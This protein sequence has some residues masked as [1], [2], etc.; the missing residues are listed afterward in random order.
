MVFREGGG[1]IRKAVFRVVVSGEMY[2]SA[3]RFVYV[4]QE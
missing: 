3:P 4:F 2:I 1:G